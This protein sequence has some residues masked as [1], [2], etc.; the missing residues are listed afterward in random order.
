[1]MD[2]RS[3]SIRYIIGIN[4]GSSLL[5]HNISEFKKMC[6]QAYTPLCNFSETYVAI[7]QVH[8]SKP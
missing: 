5:K 1:M 7:Y 4:K 3:K 6:L 8:P 2:D